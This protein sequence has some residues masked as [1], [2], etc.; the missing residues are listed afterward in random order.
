[1]ERFFKPLKPKRPAETEENKEGS[2]AGCK[3]P[4][5]SAVGG[6]FARSTGAAASSGASMSSLEHAAKI[7]TWNCNGL[8]SRLASKEDLD[9]F[10][11]FVKHEQPDIIFLQETR[12]AAA[13]PLRAKAGDGQRR[14]RSKVQVGV[15]KKGRLE[16]D[17]ITKVF[18]GFSAPLAMY[19]P[20][21]SL[22]D[23]RYAGSAA[24]VKREVKPLSVRFTLDDDNSAEH[25]PEGRI[26]RL[27]FDTFQLLATYTP[28]NGTRED[29]QHASFQRRRDWDA[30]ITSFVAR[31]HAAAA[32]SPPTGKPLIYVG[33]LNCAETDADLSHPQFFRQMVMDREAAPLERLN[34]GQPGCT[35]GE[36]QRFSLMRSEGHLQ[37]AFRLHESAAAATS[38]AGGGRTGGCE[39]T[40]RGTA[41]RDVA[42]SGRYYGK[43]MRIDHLLVSQLL[44]QPMETR[45]RW[46]V[47]RADIV[48]SGADR[49]N[50]FGSD[51]CPMVLA[52]ERE[53]DVGTKQ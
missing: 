37:D 11:G 7:V 45:P 25:D 18:H 19:R 8:P 6:P 1:M 29:A 47:V 23:T 26:V 49:R 31:A 22:A 40:W 27:E 32:A 12:M 24:L 10:V 15:G 36:R 38:A 46:R 42:E 3:R 28:N 35:R 50:F 39:F 13:C 51:H 41:G 53:R 5:I 2:A 44:L 17:L 16:S 30:K 20:Y 48:G 34:V 52:L 43:G 21:W 9:T 33:D 14:Q 4:R